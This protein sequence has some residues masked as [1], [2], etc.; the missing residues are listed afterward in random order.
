MG[1]LVTLAAIAR[2]RLPARSPAARWRV[3]RATAGNGADRLGGHEGRRR[4]QGPA[5]VT[6]CLIGGGGRDLLIGGK[7]PDTLRGGAR[8]RRVQHARRGR[9]RRPRGATGSTPATAATDE[10]NC[11]A[12]RDLAI[13]D[14]VEDGVYDC[15]EVQRAMIGRPRRPL[16]ATSRRGE[17][18]DPEASRA[19]RGRAPGRAPAPARLPRPHRG[20][21]RGAPGWRACC[22]PRRW[23]PRRPSGRP[24]AVPEAA[25]PADRHLR[26]ADD[27]EPLLRPLLRLAPEGRRAAT[28]GSPTPN[29][30][31]TQ[32]SRPTT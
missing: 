29:L 24:Q 23:S 7:G 20:A 31:G 26:R 8:P 12:G 6:T 32:S 3:D 27:G 11:G 21:R 10:I 18:A 30:D 25:R 13:V 4:A 17:L 28:R 16:L 5:A 15:E 1:R 14:A 2:A 22:R 19:A 9:A